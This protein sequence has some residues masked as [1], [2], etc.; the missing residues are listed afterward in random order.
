MQPGEGRHQRDERRRDDEAR[1]VAD[2]QH[3]RLLG[4]HAVDFGVAVTCA[5]LMVSLPRSNLAQNP[6]R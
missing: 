5:V 4:W 2:D 1:A 6:A 3:A